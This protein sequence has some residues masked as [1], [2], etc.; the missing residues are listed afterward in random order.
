M[1]ESGMAAA[2][3]STFLEHLDYWRQDK[4][5]VFHEQAIFTGLWT[6]VGLVGVNT[7]GTLRYI[8]EPLIWAFFLMMALL[9]LADLVECC[10]L[11]LCAALPAPCHCL[12][13]CGT[14]PEA[15]RAEAAELER[16]YSGISEEPAR[17]G[18]PPV[19]N[20]DNRENSGTGS[21]D[22]RRSVSSE[23][24]E[25]GC[26]CL[27]MVASLVTMIIFVGAVILFIIMIYRSAYHMQSVWVHYE[28]GAQRLLDR[29][30]ELKDRLPEEVADKAT[31]KVLQSMEEILSFLLSTIFEHVASILVEVLMMLLYMVFWLCNPVFVGETVTALFKRYILLKTIASAMYAFFIYL[32]LQCLAVD[33]AIVFG[34]VSFVFN[35]I[36]EVGPIAAMFLPLPVILLD[37]RL[38]RPLLNMFLALGGQFCLKFVFANI[39]EVKLVERQN[40]FRMHPVTILF[41]IAFFGRIWGATGMLVSVPMMAAAKAAAQLM[42]ALY[43]DPILVFLEG[44]KNA[45]ARFKMLRQQRPAT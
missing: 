43:R 26:G 7:M 34:L 25:R 12:R 27:R 36:P 10:L 9:P 32:L 23:D 22:D 14:R 8:L 3:M 19:P 42:P 13:P 35:F 37:G 45:P 11:R 15:F 4:T 40:A 33:L 29:L 5:A 28:Q 20:G 18:L 2:A 16:Q 21:S 44:D 6:L 31:K 38:E 17:P 41:F 30:G 39:I 1:V 24:E